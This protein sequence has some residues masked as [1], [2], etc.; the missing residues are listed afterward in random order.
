MMG[1]INGYKRSSN[2]FKS[3]GYN[4]ES[5]KIEGIR[6]VDILNN[7]GACFEPYRIYCSQLYCRGNS[8]IKR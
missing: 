5:I 4:L 1:N 7:T 6:L 8:L 2:Y 3:D